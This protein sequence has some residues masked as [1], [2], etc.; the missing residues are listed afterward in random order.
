M[1]SW[2]WAKARGIGCP[3][4]SSPGLTPAERKTVGCYGTHWRQGSVSNEPNLLP[5]S[6]TIP[7]TPWSGQTTLAKNFTGQGVT[8]K[9]LGK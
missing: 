1:G 5:L 8:W 4:G 6:P 3:S 7:E 2:V 9:F